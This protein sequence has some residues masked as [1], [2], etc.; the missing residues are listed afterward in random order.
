MIEVGLF[1]GSL[2]LGGEKERPLYVISV[3]FVLEA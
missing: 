1:R 3:A 2:K